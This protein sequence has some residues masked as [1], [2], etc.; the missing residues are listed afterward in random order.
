MATLISV[1]R[2]PVARRNSTAPSTEISESCKDRQEIN[3]FSCSL[4]ISASHLIREPAGP[5]TVHFER[6]L[7]VMV[8]DSRCCIKR[9]RFSKSRQNL[10]A[11][12]GVQFTTTLLSVWESAGCLLD[13]T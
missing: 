10:Y 13:L 5:N 12:S 7:S 3:S 9:G 1:P 6:L 11:S 8:T 4:T 2:L